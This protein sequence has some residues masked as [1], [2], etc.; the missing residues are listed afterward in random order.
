[1]L[2]IA[3]FFLYRWR[4]NRKNEVDESAAIFPYGGGPNNGAAGAKLDES[5]SNKRQSGYHQQVDSYDDLPGAGAGAAA[6][7]AAGIAAYGEK[8]NGHG[9]S[10]YGNHGNNNEKYPDAAPYGMAG[11]GS[12][13]HGNPMNYP[14]ADNSNF[15]GR[16]SFNNSSAHLLGRDMSGNLSPLQPGS[17]V[18]SPGF[19]SDTQE[20]FS[21][22]PSSA[23]PFGAPG[24]GY[25]PL[26]STPPQNSYANYA[27]GSPNG[28]PQAAMMGHNGLMPSGNSDHLPPH[29]DHALS[30][31]YAAANPEAGLGAPDISRRMSSRTSMPVIAGL[32]PL[33][34]APSP[35]LEDRQESSGPFEDPQYEGKLYAV[36]RIFEPSMPDE[37]VILP[38]DT[39]QIV[40]AYD[41]GWCLGVNLSSTKR[42]GGGEP[43][44]G[45]FPRDCVEEMPA[46]RA[47]SPAASAPAPQQQPRNVHETIQEED[48]D[49]NEDT[50]IVS[51]AATLQRA[52]TLPMLDMGEQTRFSMGGASTKTAQRQSVAGSALR[53]STNGNNRQ[54]L[55]VPANTALPPSEFG[56]SDSE[57]T[58]EDAY[59]GF[60]SSPSPL[61]PNFPPNV[62]IVDPAGAVPSSLSPGTGQFGSSQHIADY[63]SHLEGNDPHARSMTGNTDASRLSA[64]SDGNG[65]LIDEFPSTPRTAASPN[66]PSSAGLHYTG[67]AT[68]SQRLSVAGSPAAGSVRNVKRT[69]SLIASKDA[70]VFLSLGQSSNRNSTASVPAQQQPQQQ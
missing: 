5:Y 33:P 15:A 28:G 59:G 16:G 49:A 1:V 60:A 8:D 14:S 57:D 48:E 61:N 11:Y 44:K 43:A 63:A 54:S 7:A 34:G 4:K 30:A 2:A 56:G 40:M 31:A 35:N 19:S 23:G 3:G 70:E 37:L 25:P 69:S 36:T 42:N 24:P 18:T 62:Q 9:Y 20:R 46:G 27:R 50:A 29:Q 10:E 58:V 41:D 26:P 52:P 64:V 45:V 22:I 38:G 68:P 55:S 65:R 39:I 66:M 67:A 47:V 13:A 12:M 21:N 32:A 53:S 6:A 17:F 51:Q